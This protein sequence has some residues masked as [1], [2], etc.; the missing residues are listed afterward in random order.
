MNSDTIP[1]ATVARGMLKEKGR[2]WIDIGIDRTPSCI[3]R[4]RI[5][6]QVLSSY[7]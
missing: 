7:P 1:S 3:I 5:C 4:N 2:Y 6:I